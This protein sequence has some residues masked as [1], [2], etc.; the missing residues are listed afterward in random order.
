[1][2]TIYDMASEQMQKNEIDH[3]E[4]DLYLKVT[5]VSKKIVSEYEYK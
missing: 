4:S 1:M 5:E 3:H 2:K